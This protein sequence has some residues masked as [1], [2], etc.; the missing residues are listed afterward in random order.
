MLWGLQ[1]SYFLSNQIMTMIFEIGIAR[2]FHKKGEIYY[3][4]PIAKRDFCYLGLAI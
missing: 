2:S 4:N 3:N 1:H